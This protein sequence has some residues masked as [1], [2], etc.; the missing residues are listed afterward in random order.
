VLEGLRN[1]VRFTLRYC[2]HNVDRLQMGADAGWWRQ[3]SGGATKPTRFLT[4]NHT[5]S[6]KYWRHLI[7]A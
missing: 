7:F 1:D 6:T 5:F 2:W 4:N 3:Q